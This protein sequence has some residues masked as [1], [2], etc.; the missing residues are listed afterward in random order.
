MT[1][2]KTSWEWGDKKLIAAEA[3]ISATTL[4][5][6]IAGRRSCGFKRAMDLED[7]CRRYGYKV[8]KYQWVFPDQRTHNPLF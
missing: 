2:W 1:K 6:I 4:S 3:G 8:T 5:D 7:V